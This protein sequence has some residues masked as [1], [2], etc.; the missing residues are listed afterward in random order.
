MNIHHTEDELLKKILTTLKINKDE[1]INYEIIK[2]SIDARKKPD[3]FFVYNI[4]VSA[5][6]EDKIL[7]RSNKNIKAAC[8]KELKINTVKNWS[9]QR[10]V[11]VG[12]GPSGIFAALIL[13]RS[14]LNPV[15]IER[16]EDVDGRKATVERFWNEDKLD[17]ESNVSF[18]EGG[19][20]TFSDGKLNTLVKD[21]YGYNKFVLKTL[22]E[23]GADKNILTDNKPHIGTDKLSQVIKSIRQELISSGA[24]IYF[25]TKLIDLDIYDSKIKGIKLLNRDGEKFDISCDTLILSLGHSARDTFKLLYDKGIFMEAKAFAIGIRVMH[26]QNLIDINQYGDRE[27]MNLPRASYKLTANK[28]D[29]RSAYSFCMCPGGYVVNASTENNRLCVNGMSYN[30]R[31]SGVANSAII[32]NVRVEDFIN[33]ENPSPLD[34]IEYQRYLEEIFYKSLNG[35][36]PVQNY[37]DFKNNTLTFTQPEYELKIKGKYDFS[38]IS[39]ILPKYIYETVCYGMDDFDNKIKGFASNNAWFAGLESRT[40]SPL[41]INRDENMSSNI[42]GIYPCG[43][44]AGF[45]GGIMSA[46]MDGIKVALKIIEMHEVGY[47]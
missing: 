21:V 30:D 40:S 43:E 3:I 33:N 10:P 20:G 25:N 23:H 42:K 11:I 47:E 28:E 46:A 31:G 39:D 9:K 16:G 15:I 14:G 12:F 17:T 36:I 29:E 41:R 44:G 35:K 22:Y 27:Y 4:D 8:K 37:I 7:R 1:L 26:P 32:V 45:A 24:E 34:G 5:K 13:A 6:N 19:A 38:K 18:G 2:K